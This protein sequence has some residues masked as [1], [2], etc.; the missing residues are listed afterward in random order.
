[1]TSSQSFKAIWENYLMPLVESAD[2]N[3]L[4]DD[5]TKIGDTVEVARSKFFNWIASKQLENVVPRPDGGA[6][7]QGGDQNRDSSGRI[8]ET[9]KLSSIL[10]ED[11][12]LEEFKDII[13]PTRK[14]WSQR[15]Q[16]SCL[17]F[18]SM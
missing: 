17:S 3:K 4:S 8:V 15:G 14:S 5:V 18:S 2:W 13:L 6:Q 7:N 10:S 1:M 12:S 9:F 11:H 16:N